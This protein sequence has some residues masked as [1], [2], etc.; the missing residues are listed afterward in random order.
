VTATVT[1]TATQAYSALSRRDPVLASVIEQ[2]CR[3]PAFEWHDGGRT[4]ESKFAAMLLHI[5]GQQISAVAAF[6][7]YDRISDR[8]G[9]S[10]P[11]AASIA[12][13]GVDELRRCGLSRARASYAIAL[14]DAESSGTLDIENLDD[15]SDRDVIARLT[16]VRGVG[17]WSAQ[18]FLI[19]NLARP[20][21]LPEGDIGIRRAVQQLWRLDEL[22]SAGAVRGQGLAWSP[23]RSY[24]A[25]LL[26]RSLRPVGELSDPKERALHRAPR[27]GKVGDTS[28]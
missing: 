24:A 12:R 28:H 1:A 9:E 6:T 17:L 27:T 11:T 15:V 19:H 7:I 25:A 20:D 14:A 3:P 5:V 26:W 16:A 21:V 23:Y 13:V 8:V 18:T 4:G 10:V 2:Y 22:P